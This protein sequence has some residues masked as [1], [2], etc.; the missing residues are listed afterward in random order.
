MIPSAG[1]AIAGLGALA[2]LF[3]VRLFIGP[4]LHDRLL[5][6]QSVALMVCLA[7]AALAVAAGRP[8]WVDAAIAAALGAFAALA[9]ACKF[10]RDRSFQAS[11]GE[12]AP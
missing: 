1:V 7:I 4:T 6:A 3:S 2:A 9:A 11:A 10:L 12:R 8:D 5:A